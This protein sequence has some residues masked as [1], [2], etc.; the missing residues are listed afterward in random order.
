M[1]AKEGE[2]KWQER[3]KETVDSCV[4]NDLL[5]MGIYFLEK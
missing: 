1:G 5:F 2:G 3:V 4:V